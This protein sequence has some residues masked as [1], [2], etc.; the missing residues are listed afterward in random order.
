VL[1]IGEQAQHIHQPIIGQIS[2]AQTGYPTSAQ[3]FQA[4]LSPLL[5]PIHPMIGLREDM[6]QPD[7]A[8]FSYAHSFPVTVGGDVLVQQGGHVHVVHLHHQQRKIIHSFGFNAQ[9]AFHPMSLAESSDC[10]QI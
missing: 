5:D 4:V 9:G 1:I 2:L 8:E 3:G 6:G 7:H 10:V